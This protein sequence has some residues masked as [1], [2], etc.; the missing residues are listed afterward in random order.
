[1]TR[2]SYYS[3]AVCNQEQV[4]MTQVGYTDSV[5]QNAMQFTIFLN[6]S[7][8]KFSK[9]LSQ[10]NELSKVKSYLKISFD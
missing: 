7:S 2:R 6:C 9:M 1:M 5:L 10:N 4:L 8:C 3:K